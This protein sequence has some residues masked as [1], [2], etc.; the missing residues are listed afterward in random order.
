MRVFDGRVDMVD[1][2]PST[3]VCNRCKQPTCLVAKR[4]TTARNKAPEDYEECCMEYL[5][6]FPRGGG[7]P[8]L[9]YALSQIGREKTQGERALDASTGTPGIE[10]E[11]GRADTTSKQQ[12]R[13]QRVY[14]GHLCR[15]RWPKRHPA[16]CTS[17]V[18]GGNRGT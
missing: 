12:L 6:H 5:R 8:R 7:P 17:G 9:L 11:T 10:A 18:A 15:L 2:F 1:E 4:R 14:I 16:L 13:R 3:I